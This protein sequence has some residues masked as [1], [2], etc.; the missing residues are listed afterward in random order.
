MGENDE[1]DTSFLT[2]LKLILKQPTTW[3]G[4]VFLVIYLLLK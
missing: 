3:L 4:I 1:Y 2:F